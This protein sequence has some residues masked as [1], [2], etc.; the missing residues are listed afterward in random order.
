[1]AAEL[2]PVL[3]YPATLPDPQLPVAQP[4]ALPSHWLKQATK[5]RLVVIDGTCR[6]SRNMLYLNPRLHHLQRLA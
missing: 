2:R 6:K 4:P 3:L 5:L 1:M